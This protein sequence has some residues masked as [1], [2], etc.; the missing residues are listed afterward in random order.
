MFFQKSTIIKQ[1]PDFVTYENSFCVCFF[2]VFLRKTYPPGD[3]K[4]RIS[5][6]WPYIGNINYSY[7]QLNT[8]LKPYK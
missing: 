1:I 2:R 5:L 4:H 6:L 7:C 3:I 8:F